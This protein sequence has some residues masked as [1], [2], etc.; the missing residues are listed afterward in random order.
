MS[1]EMGW[2]AAGWLA[3][4]AV[5]NVALGVAWWR[6]THA[7]RQFLRGARRS[8]VH[9]IRA[10]WWLGGWWKGASAQDE[11]YAAQ[12]AVRL[13]VVAGHAQVEQNG[14]I[15]LTPGRHSAPAEPALAALAACLHHDEGVTVHE[16]LTEPRCTPFRTALEP[17]RAPLRSCF[18]AYR[19]PALFAALVVSFGMSVH[20]MIL[21]NGVPGLSD[22]DPGWWILLWMAPWAA[23]SVLA[24]AWPPEAS[25][26]WPLFTRRCRAVVA[27]S[28]AGESPQTRFRVS[29]GA[30]PPQASAAGAD[31]R[32]PPG[33]P[34][35]RTQHGDLVDHTGDTADVDVDHGGGDGGGFGGGD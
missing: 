35:D 9:P 3:G 23:L 7:E 5:F 31:R 22:P 6:R 33:G 17:H 28:L 1:G 14:R 27:R 4:F 21:G 2:I 20:A 24:A 10:G 13:L 32:R 25:R 19:V 16:L 15:T 8:D 12:V 26:P 30:F 34:T 29:V 18:G 11:R